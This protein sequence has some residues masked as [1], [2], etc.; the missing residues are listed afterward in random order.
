MDVR[1]MLP[2]IDASPS[3]FHA[4]AD[5]GR[6][7]GRGRVHEPWPRR[8]AWPAGPGPPL[9]APRREP[10]RLGHRAPATAADAGFRIIGAHTDSPNL[11]VK[12][13]AGRRAG[14][15][16]GSSRWRSTA[17]RSSTRGS[18]ATSACPGGSSCAAAAGADER[19][20]LRRPPLLRVPQ[21]AIH[22]DREI[23]TS[24]P[25]AQRRS[26]TSA[27]SGGSGDVDA[28]RVH[29]LRGRA[30]SGSTP[31]D[32][33]GLGPHGPRPHAR[34]RSPASTRSSSARR[35][36]DNL[37][38][39]WAGLEALLAVAGDDAA[40][41]PR[42]RCSCCS[43][44]RRS[45]RPPTG[46]PP[47][48]C[49]PPSSSGSSPASA[50]AAT[51][52]SARW[53]RSLCCSADMAHA[54][55]PNYADRHEPGHRIAPQRRP[56]AEGE[57][58]PPLRHRRAPAPPRSCSPA[59]RPASRSSATPT[60][61]TCPAAPRSAP[62]RPPRMGIPTFDVGAPQLAMHSAR[63]LCGADDPAHYAAAMAAFL[64]PGCA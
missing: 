40:P 13:H 14:R 39:S 61:A 53:P 18:T 12:P 9:R 24:G 33:L 62:S 19:L 56:G 5:G 45:A 42:S 64:A 51:T 2:F 30:S 7:P 37:C 16:T 3:P 47:P 49:C 31:D 59:S 15:A 27:R 41:R 6:P 35:A 55:H 17:A 29:G 38:S 32:V 26:S 43:T 11:R 57:Q 48:R 52:S 58:Q 21:L 20:L 50:A 10:R 34:A 46:A 63:E 4:C 44:T 60:A 1:R 8:D 25:A 22:L 23:T 36:L 54:T 28:R